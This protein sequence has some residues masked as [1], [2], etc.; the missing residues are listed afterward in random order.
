MPERARTTAVDLVRL[1]ALIGICLVNIVFLGMPADAIFTP[2]DALSDR[3]AVFGIEFFFQSKFFL[4]FSFLFGW[5]IY[6]QDASARRAGVSFS[7]RY[8]RRLAALAVFGCM[9]AVLVFTG[10]ILLIY[11][12][13]G[14]LIWP[15]QGLN[16]R[17]LVRVGYAMLP[18]ALASLV[19][20]AFI[21]G[22]PGIGVA[23]DGLGGS[24]A[25]ATMTR[26]R[27]WPGTLV[28]L[29]LFQG[30]LAFG[31]FAFGLAAGK[32]GFFERHSVGRKA[33]R[34]AV[35]W[36][37]AIGMPLNI[38][39]AAAL[40]GL[41]PQ[42]Q[43]LLS[44]AGFVGI[45]LG[46]PAFSAA[47]LHLMLRVDDRWQLPDLL[48]AAGRNSLSIYVL[49]GVIAGFVFGGY[50][51]G[52][53]GELSFVALVAVGLAVAVLAILLVGLVA[54]RTGRGPLEAILRRIT[55]LGG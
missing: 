27:D 44:L 53:F 10:D 14:L 54:Q 49:Q 1:L 37:L 26:L 3:A 29:L 17:Q 9:H 12:L 7:G 4:L 41:I 38:G 19:A 48:V 20:L 24:F 8:A 21:L 36:L 6:V 22:A 50:G 23:N 40:G 25:E 16:A 11:A 18:V 33:L 15:L 35:P 31:A 34:R 55:Y 43:E 39:Y 28:F 30:P 46:G 51:L 45:A 13:L 47:Y 2:P 42:E 5:G 52:L 32:S